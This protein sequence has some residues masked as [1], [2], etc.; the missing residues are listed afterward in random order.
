[1]R[2][3]LLATLALL[4]GCTQLVRAPDAPPPAQPE[5]AWQRVLERFVD[6]EGRV[7]Y[8][9]L[10]RERADLDRFV[11][12][13]HAEGVARQ[14]L[15]FHLDAYNALAMYN[16]LERGTPASLAGFEKLRFFLLRRF[17]LGGDTLSLYAYENDVIRKLGEPRAHFALN[18][19]AA[20]CPRLPRT[21]FMAGDLEAT[22][23]REARRFLNEP[24]NVQV[25]HPA[26]RVRL[27]AILDWYAEDFPPLL[28]Y[29]NRYRVERIPEDYRVEFIS[30]DW[31][32]NAQ[33]RPLSDSR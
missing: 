6:D 15:A 17:R 13:I 23:E 11:A 33:P 7:D 21:P 31:R 12:W 28:P 16:A 3:I 26:R 4:A 18:C 30:Y 9:G 10:A 32:L 2:A 19:M 24:R 25:D 5:L 8:A 14:P 1:M 29:V 22:L 20:G 27:S